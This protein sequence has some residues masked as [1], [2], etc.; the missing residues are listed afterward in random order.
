T[1]F[2]A[3]DMFNVLPWRKEIIE[4]LLARD[5]VGF[6]IARYASNFVSVARSLMDVDEVVRVRVDDDFISEGTA[7]TERTV[8]TEL[9]HNGRRVLISTAG[10]GVDVDFILHQAELP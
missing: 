6:H 5:V 1:P 4:S 3:A 8:P 2:P 9:T 7:L 10:V